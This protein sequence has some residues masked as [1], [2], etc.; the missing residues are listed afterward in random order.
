MAMSLSDVLSA[1]QEVYADPV[2]PGVAVAPEAGVL[3]AK[4]ELE[5]E[6]VKHSL[7][8]LSFITIL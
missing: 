2:T 6:E 3:T 4:D 8:A 7:G 1:V 5:Y